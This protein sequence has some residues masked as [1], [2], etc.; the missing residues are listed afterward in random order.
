MVELVVVI[1]MLG[2][3][4]AMIGP[5]LLGWTGRDTEASALKLA[6]LLSAAARRDS[7][8]SQRVAIKFDSKRSLV[9]FQVLST[10]GGSVGWAGDPLVADVS[11]AGVT[12]SSVAADG[13][14]LDASNWRV[15]FAGGAAR[16]AIGVV[17]LGDRG[18][19]TYRVDL[20]SRGSRAIVTSGATPPEGIEPMDLDA[21]GKGESP[22]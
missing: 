9:E 3:L 6:E 2:V 16:P 5:R 7:L 8:S 4:G 14:T 12:L 20:P 22:W 15:E 17:L 1:V 19:E 13:V 21:A 18:K 11:L 10:D